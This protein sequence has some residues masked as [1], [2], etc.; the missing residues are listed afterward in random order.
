MKD[1]IINLYHYALK[2]F[3]QGELDK[4]THIEKD[5]EMSIMIAFMVGAGVSSDYGNF[6]MKLE[7][8]IKDMEIVKAMKEEVNE[9]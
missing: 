3:L 7:R 4:M 9:K 8:A 6:K 1:P 2:R 5:R